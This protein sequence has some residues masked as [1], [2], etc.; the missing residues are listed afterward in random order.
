MQKLGRCFNCCAR[1]H[2][3]FE[4][5]SPPACFRCRRRGHRADACSFHSHDGSPPVSLCQAPL[6]TTPPEASSY[7][8]QSLIR[9]HSFSWGDASLLVADWIADDVFDFAPP[10]EI[11]VGLDLSCLPLIFWNDEALSALVCPFGSFDALDARS[12]RWSELVTCHIRLRTSSLQLIPLV[13]FAVAEGCRYQVRVEIAWHRW[14]LSEGPS[15]HSDF[16]AGDHDPDDDLDADDHSS[17][18]RSCI[19]PSGIPASPVSTHSIGSGPPLPMSSSPPPSSDGSSPVGFCR[20]PPPPS[21]PASRIFSGILSDLPPA[22]G[23]VHRR[24]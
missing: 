20:S 4:C 18:S 10:L 15:S 2:R 5:R 9:H 22:A 8:K 17:R 7:Y 16:D 23:K 19:R 13:I 21:I 12:L 6:I 24:C 1:G 11:C 14:I 3:I